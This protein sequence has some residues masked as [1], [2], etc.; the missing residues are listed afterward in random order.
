MNE[1][2][3][4]RRRPIAHTALVTDSMTEQTVGRLG[5]LSESGLLLICSAPLVEEALYQLHFSL[6]DEDGR[7]RGV[8]VG[9]QALWI[10]RATASGQPWAGIRFIDVA[11]EDAAFLRR[12]AAAPGGGEPA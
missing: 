6:P 1:Y 3:R 12:W 7:D 8:E 11:P 2:R 9:V 4:S 10:D 5:N